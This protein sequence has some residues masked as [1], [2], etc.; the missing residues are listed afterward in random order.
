MEKIYEK[1]YIKLKEEDISYLA[2]LD[3]AINRCS[4]NSL[5]CK[6]FFIVCLAAFIG[7]FFNLN[8][9]EDKTFF[10]VASFILLLVIC[11]FDFFHFSAEKIYRRRYD[12]VKNKKIKTD[13]EMN[14]NNLEK[15]KAY[16]SLL[17]VH[18][19]C[20]YMIFIIAYCL[21]CC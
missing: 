17:S 3:G 19:G 1:E 8:N 5:M 10:S 18:F 14:I 12:N 11:F 21:F 7:I 16:E 9:I 20:F 2:M 13:F 4:S 6:S 15:V